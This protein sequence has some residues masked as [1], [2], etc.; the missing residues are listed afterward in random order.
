[1]FS[2]HNDAVLGIP[3]LF[4]E[5]CFRVKAVELPGTLAWYHLDI[6]QADEA[7]M[8]RY[9]RM[10]PDIRSLNDSIRSLEDDHT[11]LS[12]QI[13]LPQSGD[14]AAWEMRS[15]TALKVG[16]EHDGRQVVVHELQDGSVVTEPHT[17]SSASE[18]HRVKTLYRS[19]HSLSS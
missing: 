8:R 12:M 16:Y 4:G 6:V 14:E 11:I 2:I 18:L 7:G 19:A 17:L 15:V 10:C 5:D 1:M 3:G 9:R 13:V